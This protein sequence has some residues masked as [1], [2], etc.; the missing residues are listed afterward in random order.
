M[1]GGD[2]SVGVVDGELDALSCF[3]PEIVRPVERTPR[4]DNRSGIGHI[5]HDRRTLSVESTGQNPAIPT[6]SIPTT[7]KTRD[8]S[9]DQ[10]LSSSLRRAR[11]PMA[12]RTTRTRTS[13]RQAV[14]RIRTAVLTVVED[15]GHRVAAGGEWLRNSRRSTAVSFAGGVLLGAVVMQPF[16]NRHSPE[17]STAAVSSPPV[18]AEPTSS[19]SP[20]TTTLIAPPREVAATPQ[21]PP[22]GRASAPGTV[23]KYRGGLRI[24]SHPVGATVFVNNQ[25]V[26]QTPITLSSLPVGSRAVRIELNGY[27]AWSH[28]VQIV[29]NQ[30]ASVS[31]HLEAT[32]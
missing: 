32:R 4:R 7:I 23:T 24:D 1:D 11:H 3:L 21:D 18:T 17:S 10:R 15:V 27:A 25:R 22:P 5:D 8:D 2:R 13:L 29:A 28:V 16:G 31:A 14:S 19:P 6:V 9:D 26:G 12:R 30:S 20:V